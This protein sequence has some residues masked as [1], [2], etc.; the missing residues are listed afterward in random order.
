MTVTTWT[1]FPSRAFKYAGS[2]ATRVLPSPVT[3][4]AMAPLW[5]TMPPINWTSKWRMPRFRRPASRQTAK[6]SVSTSSSVSPLARRW[7]NFAVCSANSASVMAWYF[8]SRAPIA[9]TCGCSFFRY[10]ALDEPNSP[11]NDRSTAR[12]KPPKT[13]PRTSQICV[14][15]SS[16]GSSK[17]A[18][19]P[20]KTGRNARMYLLF[21]AWSRRIVHEMPPWGDWQAR[22]QPK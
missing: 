1:P 11:V 21:Y 20:G 7:R 13:S 4:S 17:R 3:I 19:R 15:I 18:G 22:K 5:S 9:A 16:M 6:A 10:R 2:V 12:P 8:D 14:R